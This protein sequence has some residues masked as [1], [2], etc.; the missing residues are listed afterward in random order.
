MDFNADADE[1]DM[2]NS[3]SNP[4]SVFAFVIRGAG[5]ALLAFAVIAD[6]VGA[7]SGAFERFTGVGTSGSVDAASDG[8]A[9]AIT[10]AERTAVV[11]AAG[12][13]VCFLF[14][15]FPSTSTDVRLDD[16]DDDVVVCFAR[17]AAFV[18]PRSVIAFVVMT[19]ANMAGSRFL[20]VKKCER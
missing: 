11:A 18:G 5:A 8:S 17:K 14:L 9:V 2:V 3:S 10:A 19:V 4:A 1:E 15:V 12:G 20:Y 13:E 7:A 16:D 6:V